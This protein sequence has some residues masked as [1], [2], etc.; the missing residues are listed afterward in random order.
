MASA[1]C[2]CQRANLAGLIV[3]FRPSPPGE[4]SRQRNPESLGRLG[5]SPT[6]ATAYRSSRKDQGGR[7]AQARDRPG[8]GTV[9]RRPPLPSRRRSAVAR[10]SPRADGLPPL[11][12]PDGQLRP[13][14]RWVSWATEPTAGRTPRRSDQRAL[15]ADAPR[16]RPPR[17][18]AIPGC[19]APGLCRT[20][21]PFRSGGPRAAR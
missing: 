19:A 15:A 7:T 6:G 9:S 13:R 18:R 14:R 21:R 17:T 16:G 12:Q 5:A 2:A 3:P 1:C 8:A 11:H 20:R 10:N 4:G